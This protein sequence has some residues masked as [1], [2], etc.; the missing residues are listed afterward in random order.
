[1]SPARASLHAAVDEVAPRDPVIAGLVTRVGSIEHRP[2]DP[3]GPLAALVR[4]IVFQQLARRA[5]QAIYGRVRAAAGES[6]T[7]ESLSAVSD[8]ALRAAGPRARPIVT[9]EEEKH[10]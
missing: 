4:A 6:L 8:A 7:P 5:A 2:R 3:D 9:A 1:M 10:G